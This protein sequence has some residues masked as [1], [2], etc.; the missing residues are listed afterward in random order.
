VT[1]NLPKLSLNLQ[2]RHKKA[3]SQKGQK[4]PNFIWPFFKHKKAKGV[5]KSQKLQIWCQK[6][7]SGNTECDY[8]HCS[9]FVFGNARITLWR[10]CCVCK[11]DI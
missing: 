9:T 11:L 4:K 5:E 7:Q 10:I 8:D 3:N 6:S 1:R 2:N